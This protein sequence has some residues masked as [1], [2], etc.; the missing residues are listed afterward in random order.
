[1]ISSSKKITLVYD[2][3]VNN[4]VVPNIIKFDEIINILCKNNE[5]T[6]NDFINYYKNYYDRN[7]KYTN[8]FLGTPVY[9]YEIKS[10]FQI[11][12]DF[13]SGINEPFVYLVESFG[14]FC[15]SLGYNDYQDLENLMEREDR[16]EIENSF[17]KNIDEKILLLTKDTN[18]YILLNCFHEGH[19]T[20][21]D[22]QF[23][24]ELLDKYKVPKNKF[25]LVYNSFKTVRT[26]FLSYNYDT[27]LTK[28]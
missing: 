10:T 17:F 19:V 15:L 4:F 12:E 13:K 24:E 1:M 14:K 2:R 11:W 23:L 26:S 18:A 27:H 3:I 20:D 22:I 16:M 5:F 9:K 8:Y 6:N 25:I 21:L 28:K 7:P